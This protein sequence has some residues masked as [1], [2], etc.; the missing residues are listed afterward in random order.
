MRI[1]VGVICM[2]VLVLAGIKLISGRGDEALMKKATNTIIGAII[3]I[4]MAIFSY[5]IMRSVLN[6]F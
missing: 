3:G 4:V 1:A 6:L 5:I 2:V